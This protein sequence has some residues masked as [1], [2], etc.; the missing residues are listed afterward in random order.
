[1]K[2]K[3]QASAACNSYVETVSVAISRI[4]WRNII[5]WSTVHY[6]K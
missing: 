6:T 5:C 4:E 3:S 1:M 2:K